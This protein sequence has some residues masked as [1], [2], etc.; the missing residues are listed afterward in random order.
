MPT[1]CKAGGDERI[2]LRECLAPYSEDASGVFCCPGDILLADEPTAAVPYPAAPDFPRY[3]DREGQS[4]E[5]DPTRELIDYDRSTQYFR[6]LTRQQVAEE[7]SDEH[8]GGKLSLIFVACDYGKSFHGP[9]G[10]SGSRCVLF[11][12][13]HSEPAIIPASE[14]GE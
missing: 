4:Y 8:E 11:A 14:S 7:T 12:D 3:F 10:M 9:E 2:S 5:Y 13:G 6:G 1:V